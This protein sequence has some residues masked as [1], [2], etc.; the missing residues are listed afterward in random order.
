M[1]K[2][3]VEIF[4]DNGN[5]ITFTQSDS[6]QLES[7]AENLRSPRLL[8]QPSLIFASRFSVASVQCQ[9][10]ELIR[11]RT[12]EEGHIEPDE[13]KED[14]V[15]ITRETFLQEYGQLTDEEK[16]VARNASAGDF[17]TTYLQIRTEGG[18]EVYLRLHSQKKSSQEGR[19]FFTHLF[20]RPTMEFRIEEGGF[21]IIKPGKVAS[22]ITYPGPGVDVL[23]GNT[24]MMD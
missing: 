23:P 17:I 14:I 10:I 21:G 4:T 24:F 1:S 13:S 12:P 20:N 19:V 11:Y 8:S 9:R 15:E 2:A 22:Q 6:S 5:C 18:Q 7:L 16:L 3:T